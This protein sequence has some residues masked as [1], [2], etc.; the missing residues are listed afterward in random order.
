MSD[1]SKTD[2][3]ERASEAAYDE[4]EYVDERYTEPEE[5]A[6][7]LGP[8]IPEPP[9][10]ENVDSEL[11]TQFWALV[12]VFNVALMGI[13]VGA[14]FAVFQNQYSFGIQLMLGGII[15][16]LYGVYRYRSVR[17]SLG[18]QNE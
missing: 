5:P 11:H 18:D 17:E 9:D 4:S 2:E 8:D 7:D 10:P 1:G 3:A 13:S 12:L 15:I 16:F 14:M 6:V